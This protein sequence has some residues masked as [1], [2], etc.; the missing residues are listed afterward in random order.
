LIKEVRLVTYHISH[1]TTVRQSTLTLQQALVR[2]YR[3]SNDQQNIDL[4]KACYGMLLFGVPNLGLRNEQLISIVKGQPNE[5]LIR[6][7]V[8]D[9]D[10]EPSP[11]LKRISDQFSECCKGQYQVV[12][13]FELKRSPTVQVRHG[14]SL[15]RE[16]C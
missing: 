1:I 13:F 4:R 11:F 8:V 6:D 5:V 3:D 12:S 14:A 16:E 7:L 10:S 2:A 9:N 15:V